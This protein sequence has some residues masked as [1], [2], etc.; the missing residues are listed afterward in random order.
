VNS[1]DRK[2][3]HVW[4]TNIITFIMSIIYLSWFHGT[5]R[6]DVLVG[7]AVSALQRA[8]AEVKQ[9][10]SGIGWMTKIVLSWAP[11]CFIKHI[12]PLVP[13]TFAVV[14]PTNPHWS[15]VLARSPYVWSMRKACAPTVG[16][17]IGWWWWWWWWFQGTRS[18]A[19]ICLRR[20][21]FTKKT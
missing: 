12:R 4:V 20:P 11:P 9:R 17:L 19:N 7:P 1:Q 15:R 8:I 13:A 16:A 21:Y 18:I 10:W 5:G 2:S 14:A 3:S 6:S